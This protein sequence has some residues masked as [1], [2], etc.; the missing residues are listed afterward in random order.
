ML[1]QPLSLTLY[2]LVL[3][4]HPHRHGRLRD[5]QPLPGAERWPRSASSNLH[6]RFGDFIAVRGRTL[7][8]RGRRV[9]RAARALGL[10]QDDDAAD[11]RRPGAADRRARSCSDGEDVTFR[12]RA[13]RDIAFVFQLFALYPHM[14]VRG[15]IAFPLRAEG[16]PRAEIRARVE[17]GRR[18]SC[19]S[20]HLLDRP[21]G[22][23]RRRRP[24]ARGARPRHRPPAQGVP[25]GRAAGHARRRVPRADVRGA[26]R[27]HDRIGAT[28]VYVTHDQIEAMAMADRIAVMNKGEVLQVGAAAGDLRSAAQHVRRRLHRQPGHELPAGCTAG[29]R[30]GATS[31][32]VDGAEVAVPRAARAARRRR[33]VLGRPARA[34]PPRRRRPAARARCSA[35]NTWARAR[36]SRSTPSAG[37]LRVRAADSRRGRASASSVGLGFDRGDSSL[38][39][40][41]TRSARCTRAPVRGEP[42]HG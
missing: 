39:D 4:G 16:M 19:A 26:A 13:Q 34:C 7:H 23:S 21:V 42:R 32:R 28:T 1:M 36:S 40:A 18:G 38:F 24:P 27:L 6:K 11:D 20:S 3:R 30:A 33:A 31:L 37:R 15:N 14:N 17:R 41:A 8:H 35:S 5:R 9:L 25:D 2:S 10:R 12:A 22:G 29:L